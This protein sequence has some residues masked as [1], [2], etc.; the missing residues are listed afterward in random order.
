LSDEPL[1]IDDL[2]QLSGLPITQVS[3]T[4]A[5]MELKGL[6]RRL[7]GM[8]YTLARGGGEMYRLD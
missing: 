2:C 7:E 5:L 3:S 1:H 4:L 6:V 8:Q